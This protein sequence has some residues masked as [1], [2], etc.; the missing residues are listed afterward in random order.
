MTIKIHVFVLLVAS[1]FCKLKFEV[2]SPIAGHVE[3]LPKNKK[4]RF[5]SGEDA[6]ATSPYGLAVA[7]GIGGSHFL[8][9]H[10][11]KVLAIRMARASMEE[12]LMDNYRHLKSGRYFERFIVKRIRSELLLYWRQSY[13]CA[14]LIRE[15][16]EN[17]QAK[18]LIGLAENGKTAVLET[19]E[20]YSGVKL[21]ESASEFQPF[22][23][24][25]TMTIAEEDL[26]GEEEEDQKLVGS[27]IKILELDSISQNQ[28]SSQL[29]IN[30]N[31]DLF[32]RAD[33]IEEE[34]EIEE[35]HPI[36]DPATIEQL[37]QSAS[38]TLV[39]CFLHNTENEG[40]RLKVFQRGDS[41]LSIFRL[42]Q[43]SKD[44]DKWAF[45][46]VHMLDEG[47]IEFNKPFQF[48]VEFVNDESD[49]FYMIYD[50]AVRE[51]D[52][53]IAGSDG[54]F[55]NLHL[56][57]ITYTVN[58]LANLLATHSVLSKEDLYDQINKEMDHLADE[59]MKQFEIKASLESAELEQANKSVNKNPI[60]SQTPQPQVNAARWR[61]SLGFLSS[62]CGSLCGSR[63]TT[64]VERP[65][66]PEIPQKKT[67]FTS[68]NNFIKE[69][70][71]SQE[72]TDNFQF[73]EPTQE[74]PEEKVTPFFNCDADKITWSPDVYHKAKRLVD[75][76]IIHDVV[77]KWTIGPSEFSNFKST[78]NAEIFAYGIQ[79]VAKKISQSQ[80]FYES[81]FYINAKKW[82]QKRRQRK[83]LRSQKI[84]MED[85]VGPRSK[86]DDISVVAGL[87]AKDSSPIK[88]RAEELNLWV[89]DFRSL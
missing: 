23:L 44:K 20:L 72:E 55:D 74:T 14:S 27:G 69:E 10:I 66:A 42:A 89:E 38:T 61:F 48:G 33:L 2:H 32:E 1:I 4:Q 62:W 77:R 81:P 31:L 7:D 75:D 67:I 9:L 12:A 21:L 65:K 24:A 16:M 52:I 22:D 87:V 8:S 68:K 29:N 58:C 57:M 11:A 84:Y 43:F 50:F 46:P 36:Y 49:N 88:D 64:T 30:Q 5:E 28:A 25:R 40:T 80:G 17:A 73:F 56:S 83:S 37:A 59:F 34:E 35:P 79:R 63:D 51:N 18:G 15:K 53:V 70:N 85:F 41:L 54:L 3:F 76:C 60:I 71:N 86:P 13:E 47:Q 39:T 82:S 26:E 6:I 78:Y 19:Q 45:V